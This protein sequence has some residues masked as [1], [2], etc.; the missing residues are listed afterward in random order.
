MVKCE[1]G[2]SECAKTEMVIF[3][4]QKKVLD[5]DTKIELSRQKLY[6]SQSVKYF[7]IKIDENLN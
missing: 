6:P 7:G 5:I 4:Y 1:L 2:F 3:K